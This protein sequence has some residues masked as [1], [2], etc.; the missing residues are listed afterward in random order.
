MNT[1]QPTD[2]AARLAA[3]RELDGAHLLDQVRATLTRYVVLPDAL[4][5]VAVT[6]WI[7]ASHGQQFW[8]HAPR[9]VIKA[10]EKRCGKSRLLDIIEALC[11]HAP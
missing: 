10:P 11:R 4:T 8:A 3:G 2:A 5:G 1:D 9:L 6:L 7:V